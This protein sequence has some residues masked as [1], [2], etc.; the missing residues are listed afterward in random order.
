MEPRPYQA[1]TC[2]RALAS[3]EGGERTL[4]VAPT[5]AGKTFMGTQIARKFV[6]ATDGAKQVLWLAHRTELI[7]QAYSSVSRAIEGDTHSWGLKRGA[8]KPTD[9]PGGTYV[10]TVQSA[11]KRVQN[12]GDVGLIIVD[13]AHRTAAKTYT[14]LL[15][16]FP[17]NCRVLGLTGTPCRTDEKGLGDVYDTFHEAAKVSELIGMGYLVQPEICQID[18]PIERGTRGD[19][20]E[21]VYESLGP[22]GSGVTCMTFGKCVEQCEELCQDFRRRGYSAE[23]CTG[24]DK[25]AHRNMAL[26]RL[27]TGDLEIVLNVGLFPEGVDIPSLMAVQVLRYTESLTLWLQICGRVMRP[28]S[29]KKKYIIDHGGNCTTLYPPWYDRTWSLEKGCTGHRA[30]PPDLEKLEYFCPECG[31]E[32]ATPKSWRCPDCRAPIMAGYHKNEGTMSWLDAGALLARV[33]SLTAAVDAAID[34]PFQVVMGAVP[35]LSYTELRTHLK[36]RGMSID[37][38]GFI[39]SK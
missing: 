18:S 15:E 1:Q 22:P 28:Y 36:T 33:E 32:R 23:I 38:Y 10:C 6:K 31:S 2:H 26:S 39:R 7:D 3:L 21:T 35:Q 5:G 11:Y 17:S 30:P 13:E 25:R 29:G 14:E 12:P 37:S 20:V 34:K 24:K 9:S 8:P 19:P 27:S 4:I 16:R